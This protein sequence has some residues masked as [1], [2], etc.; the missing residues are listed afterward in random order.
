ML[1]GNYNVKIN[2]IEKNHSMLGSVLDDKGS[3][4]IEQYMREKGINIIKQTTAV[5]LTQENR[6]ITS[7]ELS[8]GRLIPSDIVLVCI[9]I[10][11]SVSFLQNETMLGKSGILVD[12][13]L[14]TQINNIYA[15]GDVAQ[16]PDPIFEKIPIFHPSWSHAK[17]HGRIAAANMIGG[18]KEYLSHI[19]LQKIT[20]VDLG[21]ISAGCFEPNKHNFPPNDKNRDLKIFQSTDPFLKE[22]T[23]DETKNIQNSFLQYR[24]LIYDKEK[25]VGVLI[26]GKLDSTY[27][28]K[29]VKKWVKYLL[30]NQ[31]QIAKHPQRMLRL[32]FS[33]FK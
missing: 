31:P 11:P 6:S 32:D 22:I 24:K 9:G 30:L 33:K 28:I 12:S 25:L 23:K 3:S 19:H 5:N 1:E 18:N 16:V 14:Q 29:R 20:F 27:P 8:N 13:H 10:K 7:V 15:A 26:L 2:V 17:A 21:F 4:I